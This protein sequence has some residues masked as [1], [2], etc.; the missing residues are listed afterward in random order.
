MFRWAPSLAFPEWAERKMMLPGGAPFRWRPYQRRIARD[1]FEPGVAILALRLFSGFGKT[2][3]LGAGFAYAMSEHGARCGVRF[4]SGDDG[5]E[6]LAEECKP[7]IGYEETDDDG[8]ERYHVQGLRATRD[9]AGFL[10]LSNNARLQVYGTSPG[11]TRRAQLDIAM[12]EEIDA[13]E[14][15]R[16][17][18]DPVAGFFGRTRERRMQRRWAASYPSIA[19][20]SRIDG[21]VEVSQSLWWLFECL[22][23]GKPW[24]PLRKHVVFDTDSAGDVSEA[25]LE[26][27][28]CKERFNDPERRAMSSDA[29]WYAEENGG[30]A[31]DLDENR[32]A[33]R[34]YSA[35]CMISLGQHDTNFPD[36][37]FEVAVKTNALKRASNPGQAERVIV[38]QLDAE[39]FRDDAESKPDTGSALALR[40]PWRPSEEIPEGVLYIC[41]GAD[42][43]QEFIALEVV[44][45]GL[46]GETWGLGYLEI[47]GNVLLDSTWAE[48]DRQLART[49]A[50]PLAGRI[51]IHMTC[52]DSRY[53][54][55]RVKPWCK[56][57]SRRGVVP[58]VGSNQLGAPFIGKKTKDPETNVEYRAI[59]AHEAKDIVYQQLGLSRADDAEGYPPGYM[60]F[61]RVDYYGEKYFSELTAEDARMK[62]SPL[63]GQFYRHFELGPGKK[64]N[65]PLDCRVYAMAAARILNPDIAKLV[66]HHEKT[67]NEAAGIVRPRIAETPETKALKAGRRRRRRGG[68][69]G[70]FV[71]V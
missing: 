4:P 37:I 34:A 25:W 47:H 64:R 44:G 21:L 45:F 15:I 6:W 13:M 66:K 32:R 38:N 22:N 26:C 50:H 8:T 10:R 27:P 20:R 65:E 24:K 49:Y 7:V 16:G 51:P 63:D 53:Q 11:K 19:G 62:R 70:P 2:F 29:D 71:G 14:D 41:A 55:N 1:M 61:P 69:G 67:R 56:A 33:Y 28:G 40:E 58:I 52:V 43:N 60:H 18:G 39:S 17:E 36:Y 31:P 23:C 9:V 68:R 54:S 35:G 48:F 42:P 57:R 5:R 12:V 3:T 30:F 59:G 46:N